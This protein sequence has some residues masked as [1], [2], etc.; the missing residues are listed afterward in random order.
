MSVIHTWLGA[1]R[2]KSDGS[3]W[4]DVIKRLQRRGRNV[5]ASQLPLTTFTADVET[6]KRDLNAMP[7]P[8]VVVGHSYGGLVIT[9]ATSGA[10]NVKSPCLRFRACSRTGVRVQT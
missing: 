4:T 6:V 10:A 2:R 7:G 9:E 8:T 1:S 3:I 5:I